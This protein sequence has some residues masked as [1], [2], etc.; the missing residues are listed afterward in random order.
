MKKEERLLFTELSPEKLKES[1]LILRAIKHKGRIAMLNFIDQGAAPKTVTQIF[2]HINECQ[3]ATSQH[4]AILRKAK[5]VFTQ[6]IGKEVFYSVN[7]GAID[8]V[9]HGCTT[10]LKIKKK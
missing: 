4:L 1:A 10:M 2:T 7:Y 8:I 5:L 6:R 3:A 9:N